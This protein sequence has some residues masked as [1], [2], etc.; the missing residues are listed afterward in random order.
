[1]EL[2]RTFKT[3]YAERLEY[4]A[5]EGIYLDRYSEKSFDYDSNQVLFI[6]S[7]EKPDSLLENMLQNIDSDL[8]AAK[9]L[10]EAYNKLTRL[11]ASDKAFWTYL[12]HVDL[13]TYVQTRYPKVLEQ[14]FNDPQYVNR[15]WF[16]GLGHEIYHPL[17]GLWWNVCQTID[18]T[19]DYPYKYTD[20]LFKDYNLRTS[21]MGRYVSFRHKEE[22]KGILDFLMEDEEIYSEHF[23][24]RFRY[25]SQYFNRLGATKQLISLD[26][27]FFYDQLKLMRDEILMIHTDE[28]VKSN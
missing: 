16:Y 19:S 22:I 7:I 2:Q 6:P 14:D 18:S 3:S 21:F 11:Q 10:Y 5:K 15:H 17:Q 13:F 4:E 12:S 20:F 8:N 28:D 26:R 25:I 27:S 23:R 9:V 1:M 24:Q